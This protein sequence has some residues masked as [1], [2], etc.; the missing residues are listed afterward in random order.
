MYPHGIILQYQIVGT[1][2]FSNTTYSM[3]TST[4]NISTSMLLT[5]PGDY[6]VKVCVDY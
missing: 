6:I 3:N 2:N 5:E 1:E 4:L